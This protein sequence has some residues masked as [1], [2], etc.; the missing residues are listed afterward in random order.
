MFNLS[1]KVSNQHRMAL[2]SVL[3]PT[4]NSCK[5]AAILNPTVIRF[6]RFEL[7]FADSPPEPQGNKFFPLNGCHVWIGVFIFYFCL[8]SGVIPQVVIQNSTIPGVISLRSLEILQ[9][10]LPAEIT[11]TMWVYITV[12]RKIQKNGWR[13]CIITFLHISITVPLKLVPLILHYFI[14]SLR[15]F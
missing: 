11:G 14:E 6:F 1:S 9:I 13:Y 5:L 15:S 12:Y 7:M 8:E 4:A 10:Q 3:L 2:H